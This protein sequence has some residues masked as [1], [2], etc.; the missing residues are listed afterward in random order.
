MLRQTQLASQNPSRELLLQRIV[1]CV[2]I[3]WNL[4]NCSV[5]SSMVLG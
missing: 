4:R 1:V 2:P 3:C 5:H